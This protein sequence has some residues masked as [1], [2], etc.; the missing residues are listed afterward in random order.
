MGASGVVD[1]Q[2]DYIRWPDELFTR[3]AFIRQALLRGQNV[4]P[5]HEASIDEQKAKL[6]GF[7]RAPKLVQYPAR[8]V[9]FAANTWRRFR[10]SSKL[11]TFS[12]YY[13]YLTKIST[14]FY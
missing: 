4:G 3:R 7:L 13:V 6:Y 2:S 5:S 14:A 12:I 11:T 9:S 1:S 10:F 8:N